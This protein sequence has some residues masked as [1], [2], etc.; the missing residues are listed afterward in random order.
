VPI[1]LQKQNVYLGRVEDR[2]YSDLSPVERIPCWHL[3]RDLF[4]LSDGTV[5]FC[6]QDVDAPFRAIRL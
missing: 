3:Q 2:R 5:G 4:I 1:I 6:K